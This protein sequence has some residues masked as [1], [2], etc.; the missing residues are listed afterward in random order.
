MRFF[1]TQLKAALD[2]K[3]VVYNAGVCGSDVVYNG[4]MLKEKLL[5]AKPS[6]VLECV[7]KSDITDIYYRGGKDR[8]NE[9]G[10]HN[11]PNAKW[12]EPIYKYSYVFRAGM[13]TFGPYDHNLINKRTLEADEQ[14]SLE[15]MVSQI[16]ET[17][18]LCKSMDIT[19]YLILMPLPSDA[20]FRTKVAFQELPALVPKDIPVINLFPSFYS[21]FDTLDIRAYS[22]EKNGHYNGKGYQFM[23]EQISRVFLQ[24]E[25]DNHS[26]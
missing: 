6:F 7:N 18:Q 12:W 21:T 25:M 11:F 8:F 17:Y 1:E 9:N 13:C 23:G 15:T 4:I 22:W 16:S 10:T 24:N 2:S 5:E 19:Y 14:N 3:L 26:L 20:H